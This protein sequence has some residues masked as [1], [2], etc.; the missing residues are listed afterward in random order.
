[1]AHDNIDEFLFEKFLQGD[2]SVFNVIFERYYSAL[3]GFCEQFIYDSEQSKNIAQEAYINLWLKRSKVNQYSGIKSFLYTYAK[4][5]CL[6]YIRHKKIEERYKQ[7]Q[8]QIQEEEL[9]SMV[10]NQLRFD[11]EEFKELEEHIKRTIEKMPEKCRMVFELKRFSGL[12]NVEV[13]QKLGIT[14]KAVEA[15][16]TRAIKHLKT[17]LAPYLPVFL[18]EIFLS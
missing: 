15:N 9:N 8:L 1:M 11:G 3:S 2:E 6:N 13:A 4:S 17:A 18:L 5:A 7:K 10:L 16:M 12:K 14:E